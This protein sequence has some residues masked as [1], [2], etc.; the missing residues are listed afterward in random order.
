MP[1]AVPM[2]S[3]ESHDHHQ[4][5]ESVQLSRYCRHLEPA[6]DEQLPGFRAG[7]RRRS[8][9]RVQH[10]R[11]EDLRNSNLVVEEPVLL[12]LQGYDAE[13]RACVF[14]AAEYNGR[15]Y[16][17]G[18]H[19]SLAHEFNPDEGDVQWIVVC[20]GFFASQNNVPMFHGR[21]YWTQSDVIAHAKT[22]RLPRVIHPAHERF[23]TDARDINPVEAIESHVCVLSVSDFGRI[24]RRHADLC[25]GVYFCKRF[26]ST[27]TATFFNLRPVAFP[28][29]PVPAHVQDIID[30]RAARALLESA[31]KLQNTRRENG[32][33]S[34]PGSSAHSPARISECGSAPLS[35]SRDP[36][37]K[38]AALILRIRLCPEYARQ[39]FEVKRRKI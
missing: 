14:A 26:Y 7:I 13:F 4:D 30:E 34:S 38:R 15:I 18:D 39:E 9:R 24:Y 23:S 12:E 27:E 32:F 3:M 31:Q 36:Q 35:T 28:G 22:T 29:D 2:P 5:G 17:I 11:F 33:V 1:L 19:V 8:S 20:E 21:W 25:E 16:R 6:L 10:Q 37:A